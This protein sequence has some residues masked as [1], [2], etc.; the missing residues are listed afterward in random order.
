[1]RD[2][3]ARVEVLSGDKDERR[4][5]MILL[6]KNLLKENKDLRNMLNTMAG[7][8]GEGESPEDLSDC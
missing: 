3:E 1:V 2:L 4:E 6:T 5:L 8:I 7:F